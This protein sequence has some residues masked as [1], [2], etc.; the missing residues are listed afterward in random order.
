MCRGPVG[1]GAKRTRTLMGCSRERDEGGAK[2]ASGDGSLPRGDA[3]GFLHD[4][5][6]LRDRVPSLFRQARLEGLA[7]T[8][9]IVA[10]R[11]V[12]TAIRLDGA[13]DLPRPFHVARW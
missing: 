9:R 3:H 12:P 2:V 6:L 11:P 5:I 10:D 13:L 4:Q 1:L 8:P 7:I